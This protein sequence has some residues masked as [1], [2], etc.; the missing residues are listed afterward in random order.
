MAR[1]RA[2]A[3]SAEEQDKVRRRFID[4]ARKVFAEAGAHGLTMRRLATEAGYSPGTIYLYF[5]S[6]RELLREVWKEDMVALT[7]RF[8]EAVSE[9]S[10]LER[11]SALCHCW[12]DFWFEQPDH[13]KA[14][15]LEVER[16]YVSERAAF[17]E[18]ESVQGLHSLFVTHTAAAVDAGQ[19]VPIDP[20]VLTHSLLAAIHG[21]VTL[22]IG[23]AGFAWS[24]RK[25][26]V[27]TVVGAMLR[28]LAPP[29]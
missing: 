5:P 24:D 22:H 26:M 17:A 1:T 15:F 7:D 4:C 28:G 16:Q 6:R 18:D 29:A 23:N 2:R 9:G 21:V 25:V 27:D 14:M 19:L 11:V 3:R 12:A 10:P 20:V 8:S 13:F